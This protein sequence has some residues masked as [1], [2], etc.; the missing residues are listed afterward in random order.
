VSL[1][2]G[3][4]F[5]ARAIAKHDDPAAVCTLQPCTV[6]HDLNADAAMSANVSTVTIAA[7]LAT[8]AVATVLWLGLG[9]RASAT[10]RPGVVVWPAVEPNRA[11]L[12]V[13]ATF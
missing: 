12:Q 5:G 4:Y 6:A 9:D 8:V 13:A 10:R 3:A 7:G 1:S 2:V 11:G